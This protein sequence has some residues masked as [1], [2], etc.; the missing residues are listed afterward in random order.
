MPAKAGW[1]FFEKGGNALLAVVRVEAFE[2]ML[3]F[4]LQR[5]QQCIVFARKNRLLYRSYRDLRTAGDFR[6]HAFDSRAKTVRWKNMI[7][8][9]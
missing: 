9:P 2:L 5:L 3:D 8:D 1:T 7:Y 6:G 4:L